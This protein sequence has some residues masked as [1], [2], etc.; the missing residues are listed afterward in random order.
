[1][2]IEDNFSFFSWFFYVYSN[3]SDPLRPKI[4]MVTHQG[5]CLLSLFLYSLC[6]RILVA[7]CMCW[8]KLS[9]A[10][11]GI[12]IQRLC[13]VLMVCGIHV[14]CLSCCFCHHWLCFN[15]TVLSLARPVL[16]LWFLSQ[17]P[18]IASSKGGTCPNLYY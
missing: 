17:C 8:M 5:K 15:I 14:A 11:E 7:Q 1:M 6:S 3:H 4:K 18:G 16:Y 9:L 10:E 13:K 12:S 2:H